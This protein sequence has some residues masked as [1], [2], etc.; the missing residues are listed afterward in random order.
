[1]SSHGHSFRECFTFITPLRFQQAVAST[2]V[3]P[4]G[5]KY[6]VDHKESSVAPSSDTLDLKS[7]YVFGK[8]DK[9]KDLD[10]EDSSL[11]VIYPPLIVDGHQIMSV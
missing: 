11:G 3:L 9:I 6:P 2:P 4:L 8:R 10:M 5:W 7:P 1:M